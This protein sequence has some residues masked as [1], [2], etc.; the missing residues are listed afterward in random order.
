MRA[1]DLEESLLVVRNI[2]P[3]FHEVG[4]MDHVVQ[5]QWTQ[6]HLLLVT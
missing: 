6:L 2:L 5:P 4:S 1:Y 3:P